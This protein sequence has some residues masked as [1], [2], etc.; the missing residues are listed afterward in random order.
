MNFGRSYK[1]KAILQCTALESTMFVLFNISGLIDD[2]ER[3]LITT[4]KLNCRH[5][6]HEMSV[7]EKKIMISVLFITS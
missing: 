1:K 5:F 4:I 7:R 3:R 2:M 6:L